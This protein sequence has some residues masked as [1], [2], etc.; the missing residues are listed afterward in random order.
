MLIKQKWRKMKIWG[1]KK[2]AKKKSNSLISTKVVILKF[3]DF[4]Y[5]YWFT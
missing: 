5:D 2:R 3:V 1:L 4:P